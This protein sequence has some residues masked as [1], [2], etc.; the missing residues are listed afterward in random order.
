MRRSDISLLKWENIDF[1]KKAISKVMKKAQFSVFIPMTNGLY[2]FLKKKYDNRNSLS[3]YVTP[4]L[5][6]MYRE[7]AFGISYRFKK[8]LRNL[9][10][11]SLKAHEGRSRKTSVK[12]IHSLRHT[13]CYLHGVQG[14]PIVTLHSM[15]G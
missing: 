11:E 2:V 4:S 14:T 5:A 10:I 3:D 15:V 6:K 1:H 13:F 12:D 9:G 8:M 7:N